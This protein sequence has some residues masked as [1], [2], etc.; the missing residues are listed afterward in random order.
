MVAPSFQQFEQLCEP[1]QVSG[2]MY[3]R[4]RNPK[5]GTNINI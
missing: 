3:V 4:V 5:T 2:K 1:Y